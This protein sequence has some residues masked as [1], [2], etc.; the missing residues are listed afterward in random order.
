MSFALAPW[1]DAVELVLVRAQDEAVPAGYLFL[2]VLD[3][4]LLELG[5]VAAL[6]ADEMIVVRGVVGKFVTG[7]AIPKAALVGDATLCQK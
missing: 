5:D 4:G 6:D 7:E 3:A 1:A 2:K